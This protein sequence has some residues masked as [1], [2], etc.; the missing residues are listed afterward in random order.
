[1]EKYGCVC[2]VKRKCTAIRSRELKNIPPCICCLQNG[3]FKYLR[4][5]RAVE[6]SHLSLNYFLNRILTFAEEGFVVLRADV[7]LSESDTHLGA[8]VYLS[9]T[10]VDSGSELLLGES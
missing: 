1:M 9:D 5:V 10:V 8:D 4:L 7:S 2:S 6:E 3:V